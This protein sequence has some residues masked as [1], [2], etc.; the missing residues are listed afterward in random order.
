MINSEAIIIIIIIMIKAG[1]SDE[2]I[3]L[4]KLILEEREKETHLPIF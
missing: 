1:V 4:V 3:D 2:N